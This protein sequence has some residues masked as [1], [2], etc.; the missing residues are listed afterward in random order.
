M[1]IP[2]S[3]PPYY[4]SFSSIVTVSTKSALNLVSATSNDEGNLI[5]IPKAF[6]SSGHGFGTIV[7]STVSQ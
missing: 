3:E 5:D 2:I 7:L 6:S 4:Y 1:M